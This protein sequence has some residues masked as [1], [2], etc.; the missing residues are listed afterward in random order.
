MKKHEEETTFGIGST[1]FTAEGG[2]PVISDMVSCAMGLV[3]T[4]SGTVHTATAVAMGTG[5]GA[6]VT[7]HMSMS[8]PATT[9]A[10]DSNPHSRGM[11]TPP[12]STGNVEDHTP[13]HAI[14]AVMSE[15]RGRSSPLV[16]VADKI[17]RKADPPMK[18][19]SGSS[20]AGRMSP[21]LTQQKGRDL[22]YPENMG[23]LDNS[24]PLCD[25]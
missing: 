23:F 5:I 21:S 25:N 20:L 1:T 13:N 3:P 22:I 2:N 18:R 14:T 7:P 6:M 8:T 4:S 24:H 9:L 12:L 16:L 15:G 19:R 11:D 17:P 10:E